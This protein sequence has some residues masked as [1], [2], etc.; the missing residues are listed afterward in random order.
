MER[1]RTQKE[2]NSNGM[3]ENLHFRSQKDK[4]KKIGC[5]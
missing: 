2:N 1:V 5:L 3:N 4:K